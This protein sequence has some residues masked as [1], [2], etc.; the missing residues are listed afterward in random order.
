MV[1]TLGSAGSASGAPH[2]AHLLVDPSGDVHE[3]GI[4]P[5]S[6]VEDTRKVDLLSAELQ[7][8]AR[9]LTATLRVASLDPES[10]TL[11]SHL[12]ELGFNIG[13]VRYYLAATI[14][15]ADHRYEVDKLMVGA[16]PPEDQK[17]PQPAGGTIIASVQGDYNTRTNTVAITAP[18]E[19]LGLWPGGRAHLSLIRATTGA[20]ITEPFGGAQESA[21]DGRTERSYTAGT[22]SCRNP[23]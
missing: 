10:S 13:P 6:P 19:V 12:Y 15:G 9:T 18:L 22:P 7:S 5:P 2:C 1:L 16:S 4:N 17:P 8:D 20:G 3:T 11:E 14:D 21:D 23:T